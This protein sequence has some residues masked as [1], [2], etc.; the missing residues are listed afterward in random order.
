MWK[1]RGE[2]LDS[3]TSTNI[4]SESALEEW[5]AKDPTVLGEDLLVMGRQVQVEDVKDKLDL[6]AIDGSLN[7]VPNSIIGT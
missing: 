7:T 5:I 3:L 1:V 2:N 6:L 4:P